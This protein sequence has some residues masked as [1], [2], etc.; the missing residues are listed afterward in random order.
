M[1]Q[2]VLSQSVFYSLTVTSFILMFPQLWD[3]HISSRT[4]SFDT[5]EISSPSCFI[6]RKQMKVIFLLGWTS[7]SDPLYHSYCTFSIARAP[8]FPK[9]PYSSRSISPVCT[10]FSGSTLT[11][12][13]GISAAALGGQGKAGTGCL[14][15]WLHS[16]QTQPPPE[17]SSAGESSLTCSISEHLP[18]H[19]I[20][21]FLFYPS[22]LS[23]HILSLFFTL[24]KPTHKPP[25]LNCCH[26]NP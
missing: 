10:A 12:E 8:C 5:A 1:G 14:C 16:M 18:L 19:F 13:G 21:L 6:L 9:E 17:N 25:S 22:F 20:W 7:V 24:E 11:L 15:C 3:F 23:L 26:I 4:T 2:E